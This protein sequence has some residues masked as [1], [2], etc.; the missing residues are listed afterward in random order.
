MRISTKNNID[1]MKTHSTQHRGSIPSMYASAR[2]KRNSLSALCVVCS[3]QLRGS[4]L[5]E[6]WLVE[7]YDK[8]SDNRDGR[9][10]T[11]TVARRS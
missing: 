10:N 3:V 6:L 9:R 4:T 11:V 5:R 1:S 8:K 7:W 2:R